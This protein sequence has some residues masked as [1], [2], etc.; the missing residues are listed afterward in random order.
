MGT[1]T[2]ES[3]ELVDL[4]G[5][6]CP[7]PALKLA[8]SLEEAGCRLAVKRNGESDPVLSV[9]GANGKRPSLDEA[10]RAEIIRWKQHLIA[11]TEWVAAREAG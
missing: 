8:W 5:Y 2:S 7:L 11:L 1:L 6:T 4:P 9:V 3:V 10:T